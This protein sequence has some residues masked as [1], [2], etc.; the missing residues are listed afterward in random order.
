MKYFFRSL[1]IIF[2]THPNS[3]K[4]EFDKLKREFNK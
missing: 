3:W 1:L 2:F 4:Y